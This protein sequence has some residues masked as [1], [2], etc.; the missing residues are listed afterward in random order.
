M[1]SEFL[2]TLPS[3][4]N[5]KVMVTALNAYNNRI[6]RNGIF[7]MVELDNNNRVLVMPRPATFALNNGLEDNTPIEELDSQG[8]R[9]KVANNFASRRPTMT[10]TFSGRNLDNTALAINQRTQ[11]LNIDLGYPH[12]Q[13]V[14][15]LVYAAAPAGAIGSNI[16]KDVNT[17]GSVHQPSDKETII[18][19]QQSF[20]TF[21][22]AVDNSFAIGNGFER[23]YSNNLVNEQRF[24]T[25]VP[26]GNFEAR[27][28]S[29][30][31]IGNLRLTGI[32]F[33]SDGRLSIFSV[34][35]CFV[36]PEGAGIQ[37]DN[38][39]TVNI[40]IS[41][42]TACQPWNEYEIQLSSFCEN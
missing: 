2:I 15:R 31:P 13:Q 3:S 26:E 29:E 34:P 6:V 1:R 12:R 41:G 30:V 8:Y 24:V 42:L 35:V 22:P 20:D 28:L 40:D 9:T 18:L 7:N 25:L 27:G 4:D 32:C 19:T 33:N 10:L 39:V 14:N 23:K 21:N 37:A 17:L 16:I 11:K 36:N 5:F 38:Q